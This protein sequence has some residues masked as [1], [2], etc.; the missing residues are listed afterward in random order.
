MEPTGR[1]IEIP[2]GIVDLELRWWED[3]PDKLYHYE[4]RC[5]IGKA[6]KVWIEEG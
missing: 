1:W 5:H 2:D 4:K 6:R 3:K